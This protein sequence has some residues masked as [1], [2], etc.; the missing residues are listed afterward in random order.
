MTLTRPIT[1]T[2]VCAGGSLWAAA[3][4]LAGLWLLRIG[5][6]RWPMFEVPCLVGGV[7][8]LTMGQY[9]LVVLV[10]NRLFPGVGRSPWVWW[11]VELP[12]L[13]LLLGTVGA[14][15]VFFS[16]GVLP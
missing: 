7:A 9:V 16:A 14:L 2:L 10:A 4:L 5:S 6:E 8:C 11:G 13:A 3:M 15:V 12:L 1:L